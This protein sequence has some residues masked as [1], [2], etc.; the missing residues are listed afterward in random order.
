MSLSG[1]SLTKSDIEQLILNSFSIIDGKKKKIT[2]EEKAVLAYKKALDY[3][4][5]EWYV[6]QKPL[7]LKDLLN[8]AQ[9]TATKELKRENIDL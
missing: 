3:V 6:N 1:S 9:M 8:I 5:N 4:E 2:P 7:R